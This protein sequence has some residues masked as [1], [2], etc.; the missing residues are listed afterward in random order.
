MVGRRARARRDA[1]SIGLGLA[2][3]ASL[4]RFTKQAIIAPL[5][6][7]ELVMT[8]LARG[9]TEA[10][11]RGVRRSDAIGAMAR[12]VAVFRDNA[13]ERAAPGGRGARRDRRRA[14]DASARSKP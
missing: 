6:Q 10:E 9:D 11:P 13:V 12:A 2:L 3:A 14:S 1:S 7:L 8:R 5:T 4:Q